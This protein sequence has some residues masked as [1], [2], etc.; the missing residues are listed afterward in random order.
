MKFVGGQK[1]GNYRVVRA[2]GTGGMGEVYEVEHLRLGTYYALKAFT[3]SH[4][5]INLLKKRF[6]AEGKV[7]ARLRHPNIARVHELDFDVDSGVSYFV[8][9]LVLSDDGSPRSLADISPDTATEANLKKWFIQLCSALD[10]IH[11]KGIVHRDVKPANIL[12]DESGN[13]VLSDFGI[14][15]Y[16][17]DDLR[18]QIGVTV[19]NANGTS[20]DVTRQMILGTDAYMAPEV[21]MG[22]GAVPAS[23]AYSLGL[24]FFHLLTGVWF[25]PRKDVFDLLSS[26]DVMWTRVLPRLLDADA[27]IRPVALVAFVLG[28]QW[29]HRWIEKPSFLWAIFIVQLLACIGF[30]VF[31]VGQIRRKEVSLQLLRNELSAERSVR[32]NAES[33]VREVLSK[34]KAERS[35][36][37]KAERCA[38]EAQSKAVDE[39]SA[40]VKAERCMQEAQSKVEAERSARANADRKVQEAQSKLKVEHLARESAERCVREMQAEIEY[41]R[42]LVTEIDKEVSH[43]YIKPSGADSGDT[44]TLKVRNNSK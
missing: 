28:D 23:D 32:K 5:E 3:L 36:R 4:G 34:V 1:I 31:G 26:L 14:S 17:N 33:K 7:L 2:L 25:E 37:E 29:K 42:S 43:K 22:R 12:I 19:A 10:Y 11:K 30:L 24:V 44:Q 13:A 15:R 41:W 27:G 39:H 38:K 16:V 9:D 6:M 8:M 35:A 20:V 18:R 40:R 21:R